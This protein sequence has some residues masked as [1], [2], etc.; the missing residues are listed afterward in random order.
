MMG[1]KL[2]DGSYSKGG[3]G[4]IERVESLVSTCV[5]AEMPNTQQASAF[6][7]IN[8]FLLLC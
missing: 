6:E 3:I 8:K 7:L 4:A 5:F 2:D 1:A